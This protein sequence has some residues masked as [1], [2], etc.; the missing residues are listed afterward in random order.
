MQH[1]GRMAAT[2]ARW[3]AR[4]RKQ[5]E[6]WRRMD[7]ETNASLG[8]AQVFTPDAVA[9]GDTRRAMSALGSRIRFWGSRW[10]LYAG[11]AST[12]AQGGQR[13]T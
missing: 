13:M 2:A 12:G 6:Y 3:R 9:S 4:V 7:C 1:G 5:A 10:A 11:D 8:V